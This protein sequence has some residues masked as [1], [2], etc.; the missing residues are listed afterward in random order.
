MN[1]I[2]I[3]TVLNKFDDTVDERDSAVKEYGIRFITADGRV[4]T[5]RARKGVKS[6]LQQLR[7][8]NQPRGKGQFNL[9]RHGTMQVYDI[10]IGEIRAVKVAGIFA[11]K[12]FKQT[13]WYKVRH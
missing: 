13:A 10:A 2:D 8:P 1:L 5:M 9:Q 7:K 4:R 12:D 6:P 3:G 11:F